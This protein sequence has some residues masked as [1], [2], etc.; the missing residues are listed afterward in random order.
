MS[1]EIPEFTIYSLWIIILP[2][3]ILATIIMS[4][5]D[6]LRGTK[7][8]DEDHLRPERMIVA[9]LPYLALIAVSV[10]TPIVVGPLFWTGLGITV[11]SL[12]VYLLAISA[13]VKAK[14]GVTKIGIYR[15]SRNPMYVAL[16]MLLAG[17]ILMAWQAAMITGIVTAVISIWIAITVHWSVLTEERFLEEKYGDDYLSYKQKAARYIGWR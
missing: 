9:G 3:G 5:G 13:F 6:R 1:F 14:R 2:Y 10:F 15:L 4:V 8:E 16:F 7:I 17:I 12:V 11:I